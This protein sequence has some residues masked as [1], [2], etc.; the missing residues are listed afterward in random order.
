[1][2]VQLEVIGISTV[3]RVTGSWFVQTGCPAEIGLVGGRESAPLLPTSPSCEEKPISAAGG[4]TANPGAV[5]TRK[6]GAGWE[7]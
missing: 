5:E 2:M 7:R 6:V 1:M 4:K 3:N